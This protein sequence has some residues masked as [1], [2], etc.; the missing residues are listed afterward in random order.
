[1]TGQEPAAASH[2][3]RARGRQCAYEFDQAIDFIGPAG[4]IPGSEVAAAQV[5]LVVLRGALVVVLSSRRVASERGGATG[6]VRSLSQAPRLSGRR[7]GHVRVNQW[8][9]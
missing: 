8:L 1:M 2:V 6:H 7:L 5:P 3:E 4:A 9:S